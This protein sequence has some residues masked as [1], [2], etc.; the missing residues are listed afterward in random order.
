MKRKSM[1]RRLLVALLVGAMTFSAAKMP[2]M[3][4]EDQEEHVYSAPTN[5]RLDDRGNAT[6]DITDTTKGRVVGFLYKIENDKRTTVA[7]YGV[8]SDG[9]PS[10]G[11]PLSHHIYESGTY[12]FRAKMVDEYASYDE[13]SD[14]SKGAVSVESA[15]FVYNKP[16]AQLA[17]PGNLRWSSNEPGVAEWDPVDGA[18][19][20]WVYLY[21][22]GESLGSTSIYKDKTSLD[23]S[24]R[25]TATERAEYTF[26]VRT[27]SDNIIECAHSNISEHSAGYI[28]DCEWA[29]TN[30]KSYWYEN[31]IRQGTYDD[32]KGVKGDGTVRGREICDLSLTDD[33]GQQ[34][35]WFWLDSVY[36]GAKAVGKEVWIPY[37]YQDEEDLDDNTMRARA[38]ESDPGMGDL[39]YEFM[40]D[41]KGKWV[42]YDENGRMLKG[43][44]TI[45]GPLADAYPDQAGN[46]YYYD[47]RT[48]L[49]AK[50][51]V[52]I[53][54]EEH[55]FDETT[56]VMIR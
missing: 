56:G 55:E 19:G 24:Y 40:R 54:G 17:T 52:T 41:K 37:I 4:T 21:C 9:Y 51:V 36:N 29:T 12:V 15:P 47:S 8:V 30:G 6:V 7:S 18:E 2:A 43:W 23:L 10:V 39:V 13:A 50:G 26:C 25:M 5:P 28:Q 16:S 35:V 44:I 32:P 31:G 46:T 27:L 38:N 45:E 34:G 53:N 33:T 14:M 42:R 11:F 1:G 22:N 48:G 49:M 20:Y 3:A